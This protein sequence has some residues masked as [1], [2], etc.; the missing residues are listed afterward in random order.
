MTQG[1][2]MK[3]AAVAAGVTL[4]ASGLV[5]HVLGASWDEKVFS[6][7][8]DFDS[9]AMAGPAALPALIER[10]RQLFKAKF[11][12]EDGAGRPKATQ[13]IIPTK[14]KHGV[15]PPFS[16]TSGPDSNSC[17]GCHNDPV[18][19]GS[20]DDVANV[21]VSEGFESAEFDNVDPTFSSERH[22]IALMGAGLVELL[23]REMT[24]DLQSVRYGAITAHPD[25]IV[26]LDR[27][28]GVDADLIVR[29]FSRKG[30]FTSLRQFTINAMNVHHGMEATER[31]GV[32]WTGSHDFSESGVPDA[33]TAGDI[34]AMTLFQASLAPPTV[35]K[36]LP[37]DWRIAAEKGA[38]EFSSLGCSSCHIQELPLKSML[39]TDPAPYD[40]AGTLRAGETGEEITLDLSKLPFAGQIRKNDKGEWLIPLFSDLKRHLMV[41]AEVNALGNELQAQRFVERDVFLTPRLWGVGS[42]APYGHRGNFRSIDE[43]ISAHGGEALFAR[44]AYLGEDKAARE[45][46]IAFLRSLQIE[47]PQ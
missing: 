13:A 32:R 11:T 10:G 16:R 34:S 14:R 21:F 19:G 31:F 22:T 9:V 2:R 12:T 25:G 17:F 45:N 36:D 43:I 42:T 27:I 5:T 44:N 7:H 18:V 6:T 3:T 15:N 33:V 4:M 20:G 47:A 41:D 39:F 37:D 26:D 1:G 35:K 23:A 40:M 46:V 38:K 24:A 8:V 28:E 30:V 29:P